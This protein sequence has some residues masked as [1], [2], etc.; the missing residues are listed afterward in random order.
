MK[1]LRT[2]R[3]GEVVASNILY[4]RYPLQTMLKYTCAEYAANTGLLRVGS[5]DYAQ[6]LR[7]S[8]PK[9]VLSVF[10]CILSWRRLKRTEAQKFLSTSRRKKNDPDPFFLD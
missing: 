5:S 2:L 8:R 6:S 3:D 10:I 4:S 9:T 1:P 7:T